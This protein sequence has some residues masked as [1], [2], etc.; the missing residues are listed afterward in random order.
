M[1]FLAHIFL[2]GTDELR[3]VGN[4]IGDFVKGNQW[5][6]YPEK[7]QEGILLHRF[8]D[9][10]TDTHPI[11]L[12]SIARLKPVVGRFSGI[13]VDVFYDYCLAQNFDAFSPTPLP[14]FAQNS[15]QILEN[16]YE[17]LPTKVQEFLPYMR[18]EDWLTHYATVYGITK[19]LQ[20][21]TKRLKNILDLTLALPLLETH[22][23][24]F[25]AEFLEF[26][27]QIQAKIAEK[28]NTL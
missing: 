17:I 23:T 11:V 7:I 19:A 6:E 28:Q 9:G 10:Y 20:G 14:A 26:F 13:V 3:I 2:S 8:I 27:S 4:F 18:K 5:R 1:N 16:H 21:L 25:E 12:Q 22:Y 24:V 15:Y